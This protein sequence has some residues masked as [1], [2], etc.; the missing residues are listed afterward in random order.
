MQTVSEM[1][2]FSN[3]K[4]LDTSKN[5]L[6]DRHNLFNQFESFLQLYNAKIIYILGC[7]CFANCS[8]D[9]LHSIPLALEKLFYDLQFTDQATNTKKLT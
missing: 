6:I 9:P 7:L 3:R 5:A 8:D 1:N 4:R 2:I